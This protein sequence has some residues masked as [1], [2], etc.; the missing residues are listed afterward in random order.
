MPVHCVSLGEGCAIR[1]NHPKMY[2]IK[3]EYRKS[4]WNIAFKERRH[5]I[6]DSIIFK[7]ED[8]IR[9]DGYKTTVR[10]DAF[11]DLVEKLMVF[12]REYTYQELV[13]LEKAEEVIMFIR[14]IMRWNIS[15]I[16]RSYKNGVKFSW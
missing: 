12:E 15:F 14:G 13:N 4:I 3:M 16:E 11:L 6:L 5:N 8:I 9:N 7:E 2:E 1:K 10:K